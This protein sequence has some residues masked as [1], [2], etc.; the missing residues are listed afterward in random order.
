[1]LVSVIVSTKNEENNIENCLKSV[2]N[3]EYPAEN[4]EII[5]VDNNSSDRTQE[6]I[7]AERKRLALLNLK[8]FNRGP[9]RSA[10]KNFG[11][12]QAR[13]E[14][15]L[16]LDADMELS[17]NLIREC[18]SE[19]QSDKSLVALY[20]PEIVSGKS[21]FSKVR[22]FERSFYNGTV[23]DGVR[24]IQREKFLKVGGFDEKMY[25]CED[26]DLDKRMKK[27][28]K[29]G[30]SKSP[31][32][33]NETDFSLRKY[34]AKKKYYSKNVDIYLKKWGK[35][36]PDIRK[37]FGLY[38]RYFGVFTEDGKWKNI[39][40]HPILALGVLYLRILVGINFLLRQT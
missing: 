7:R 21:F 4:I 26:W 13:G 12:S 28:G 6:I 9:E 11:V 32:Y 31:L 1:M 20:I 29:F 39:I 38:Y 27:I 35:S 2:K 36:D 3:Q 17:P 34:L 40:A 30:L 15:F 8:V 25:S 18:V 24:F 33:H 37:Q 23:I 22:R 5:V 10:Q 16:H 14:Y 19:V